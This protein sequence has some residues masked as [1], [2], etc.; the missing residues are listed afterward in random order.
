MDDRPWLYHKLT[1][2]PK[3]SG[4]LTSLLRLDHNKSLNRMTFDYYNILGNKVYNKHF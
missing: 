4:E 1:N 2:E 3:G